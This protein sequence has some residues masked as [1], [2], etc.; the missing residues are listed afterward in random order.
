MMKG[1]K[2][3]I[4]VFPSIKLAKIFIKLG[5]NHSF[6]ICLVNHFF[7]LDLRMCF[8]G[9]TGFNLSLNL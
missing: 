1:N 9:N 6:N 8:L 7:F 3:L 4:N 2:P 5:V